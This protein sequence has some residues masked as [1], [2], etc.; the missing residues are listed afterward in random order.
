MDNVLIYKDIIDKIKGLEPLCNIFINTPDLNIP[1]KMIDKDNLMLIS[2]LP[3]DTIDATIGNSNI[4]ATNGAFLCV[5]YA[6]TYENGSYLSSKVRFNSFF[7]YQIFHRT[8]GCN[9]VN[10]KIYL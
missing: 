4:K 2:S 3:V 9:F 8:V 6:K 7:E 5:I 1:N 10:L